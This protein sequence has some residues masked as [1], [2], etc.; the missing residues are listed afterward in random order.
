MWG[1]FCVLH[2][3]LDRLGAFRKH[4]QPSST[5]E[6]YRIGSMEGRDDI[7][8][9]V[10]DAA[11]AVAAINGLD[12]TIFA[13]VLPSDWQVD[14]IEEILLSP[15]SRYTKI[16]RLEAVLPAAMKGMRFDWPNPTSRPVPLHVDVIKSM[17]LVNASVDLFL[18]L[19]VYGNGGP[20]GHSNS[21]CR[22]VPTW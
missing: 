20:I 11:E 7:R 16:E 8:D 10:S 19:A 3:V 21:N 4:L 5:A 13:C 6:R 22:R 12:T 18:K 14:A 15:E 9:V 1:V 2:A 17:H